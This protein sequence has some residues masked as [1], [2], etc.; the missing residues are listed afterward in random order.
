MHGRG[1]HH[2]NQALLTLLPKRAD[3]STLGDY[4]PISLIHLV[5]KIFAKVRSLRL[6]PKLDNL[7]SRNKNAFI[8]GRCL[9]DN[10]VLVKQ[11][12][13][14]LHQLGAHRVMLKLDLTRA[15]DSLS[16]PFLFEALCQYGF[17][18]RFLEWLAILLSSANTRVLLNGEPGPS[19]WRRCGLR[20]G[21]PLSPQLFS[22]VVDILGRL[23]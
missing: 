11:T 5:V 4:R 20:Q 2:L 18:E 8:P 9:H 15:S 21:D 16:W 7:V 1:F 10:L 13:G 12:T 14:L 6:A 3:A 23:I 19:I 22:L 17:G